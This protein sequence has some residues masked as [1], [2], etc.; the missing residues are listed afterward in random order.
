[1]QRYR[2]ANCGKTGVRLY[3]RAEQTSGP[4]Y[5]LCGACR[6]APRQGPAFEQPAIPAVRS[7]GGG[8]LYAPSGGFCEHPTTADSAWWDALPPSR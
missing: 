5:L 3:R 6:T 4:V 1:M 2:C 8:R 7:G